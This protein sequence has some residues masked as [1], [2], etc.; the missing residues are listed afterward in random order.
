MLISFFYVEIKYIYLMYLEQVQ[1]RTAL[2]DY[3]KNKSNAVFS[4]KLKII[5]FQ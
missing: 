4:K 5:L 3:R 2:Q 1:T